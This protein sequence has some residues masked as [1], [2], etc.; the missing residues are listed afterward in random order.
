MSVCVDRVDRK[1][2]VAG[3]K[4]SS[5]MYMICCQKK[6]TAFVEGE[7]RLALTLLS[8]FFLLLPMDKRGGKY[9]SFQRGARSMPESVLH[10]IQ[11]IQAETESRR[12]QSLCSLHRRGRCV[13]SCALRQVAQSI[14]ACCG[15]CIRQKARLEDS[16]AP[17]APAD[18]ARRDMQG[19]ADRGDSPP[20]CGTLLSIVSLSA[21]GGAMRRSLYCGH[22]ALLLT[23]CARLHILEQ[24]LI[25]QG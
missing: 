6:L 4:S 22:A 5:T 15:S 18:A 19:A 10:T 23:T 14:S 7:K 16:Q 11:Q 13:L 1:M 24:S 3:R 2:W 8:S 17:N 25:G 9:S 12:N 20:E 21:A